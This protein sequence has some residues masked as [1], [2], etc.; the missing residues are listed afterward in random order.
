MPQIKTQT[1]T[2]AFKN[3]RM[4]QFGGTMCRPVGIVHISAKELAA[5]AGFFHCAKGGRQ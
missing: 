2:K 3:I 5:A 1:F 4:P